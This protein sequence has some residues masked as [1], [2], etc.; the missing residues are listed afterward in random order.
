ML[1]EQEFNV[2][3]NHVNASVVA[4]MMSLKKLAKKYEG[5]DIPPISK[6]INELVNLID[7]HWYEAFV[8]DGFFDE[9]HS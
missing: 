3:L 6:E 5:L 8:E 7:D 4:T 9:L 1:T 2:R